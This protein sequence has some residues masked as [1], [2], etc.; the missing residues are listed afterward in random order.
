MLVA[1]DGV[2]RLKQEYTKVAQKVNKTKLEID[3]SRTKLAALRAA[4]ESQRAFTNTAL[5][6]PA[7][8]YTQLY[9]IHVQSCVCERQG[10]HAM[11]TR[12]SQFTNMQMS[13]LSGNT[14]MTRVASSGP[15]F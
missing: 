3:D 7:V 15:S 13:G 4:R 12:V 10:G 11:R 14:R 6:Y 2:K 5:M 8:E 9:S 1:V